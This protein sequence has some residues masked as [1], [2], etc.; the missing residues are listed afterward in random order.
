MSFFGS[1]SDS[2]KPKPPPTTAKSDANSKSKSSNDCVDV[3]LG[4]IGRAHVGKTAMFGA[5]G[6]NII[7][8]D[9]PSRL[10]FDVD[11]P[12]IAANSI[13]EQFIM[14]GLLQDGEL[15]STM[16]P[17]K[18]EFFLF[19]GAK[20]RIRFKFNEVV[21]QILSRPKDHPDLYAKY[22]EELSLAD[23]LWVVV[24]CPPSSTNAQGIQK[25]RYDVTLARAFLRHALACR[26]NPR[27]CSVALVISKVDSHFETEEQAK[28]EL[29]SDSLCDVLRSLVNT[30][31][32]EETVDNAAI[33]PVSALGFGNT[34]EA[35]VGVTDRDDIFVDGEPT[36]IIPEGK[37]KDPFNIMPLVLWSLVCGMLHQ[38]TNLRE[39]D[40][41]LPHVWRQLQSDLEAT[42][43]LAVWLKQ[44]WPKPRGGEN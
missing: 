8:T 25:F 40:D 9:L 1:K 44:R 24:P 29:T 12:A 19:E 6:H 35:D 13:E 42:S 17:E 15:P 36:F 14:D 37:V 39:N 38:E 28:R 41:S 2:S 34:V 26:N 5:I 16:T 43:R 27:P 30:V 33:F 23:V 7:S 18:R 4:V 10:H 21:G 3:T 11:D 22:Q 32:D 31:Q 20:K